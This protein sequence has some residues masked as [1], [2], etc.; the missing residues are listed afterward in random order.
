MRAEIVYCVQLAWFCTERRE[1]RT[2]RRRTDLTSPSILTSTGL[3]KAIGCKS[4]EI[5]NSMQNYRVWS[6]WYLSC[7][8]PIIEYLI[9][10]SYIWLPQNLLYKISLR[11]TLNLSLRDTLYQYFIENLNVCTLKF[12]LLNIRCDIFIF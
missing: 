5:E 3:L 11:Y 12:D 1:E 2:E 4:S 10:T 7:G 6:W 8:Q 9:E